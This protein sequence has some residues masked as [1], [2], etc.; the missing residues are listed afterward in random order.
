VS[1]AVRAKGAP[2]I[3]QCLPPGKAL[4]VPLTKD[5]ERLWIGFNDERGCYHDNHIG[6]GRRHELDPLWLRIEVVRIIVD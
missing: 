1:G 3:R 2:C 6:K 4:E 5:K